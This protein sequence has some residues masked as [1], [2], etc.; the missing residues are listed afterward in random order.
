MTDTLSPAL[1]AL[2]RLEVR[3]ACE[4]LALDYSFLADSGRME[5][6]SRLFADDGELVLFGQTYR[7]PAAI[8][9]AVSAGPRAPG[10]FTVHAVANHRIDV[11]GPDRAE[12]TAAIIVYAGERK[13]GAPA[14]VPRIAPLMVGT[15]HD[16]YRRTASGWRF[17]RRAFEPLI[18]TAATD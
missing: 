13:D 10:A 18:T 12:A 5:E 17:A 7:G 8:L 9:A 16:A 3:E 11:L 4:R 6:W 1:S 2:D 14:A 15:Y